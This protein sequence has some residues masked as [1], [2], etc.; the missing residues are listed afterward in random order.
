MALMMTT[1]DTGNVRGVLCGNP[2]I[3]VFK[4][5]PYGAPTSGQN[6][7]APPQPAEK[8]TGE[9][10]CDSFPDICY[11]PEMT[12]G[13]PFM[14]FFIKEFYP[15]RYPMSENSLALNVWTPAETPTEKLPV[16]VWIHGGGLSTGYGHEM[17]FDGEAIARRGVVLVTI[18][19][20]VDVLGWFAHPD[21]TRESPYDMSGNNWLFDQIAALQWV[22]RNIGAFGGDPANVTIFGQSAGGG[23]VVSHLISSKSNGLFAKAIIQ[24]GSFGVAGDTRMSTQ[25]SAGEAWGVKACEILSQSVVGLRAMSGLEAYQALKYAEE[26]GAGPAP[27]QLIDPY[28]LP[29]SAA[30]AFATGQAKNIPLMVGSVSGDGGL[31][32]EPDLKPDERKKHAIQMRLGQNADEFFTQFSLDGSGGKIADAIINAGPSL[33][34]MAVALG[35]VKN[36]HLP[37]YVYYFDP[38]IPEH[39]IAPFVEDGLAYHS[40]EMWYIFGVLNRCWR[41]F[42]GRHFD[43][44][45]AMTD[46]WTNFA[47]TG[48]PNG[49]GLPKWPAFRADQQSMLRL[50]ERRIIDESL[51][52]DDLDRFF[53]FFHESLT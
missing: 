45:Q 22:Q 5:I 4:G 38:F 51:Q 12:P 50:N 46:Y 47:K 17:E 53:A 35:Q 41:R 11:Q 40:S 1:I 25:L 34:D 13:I 3:T 48:N 27:R 18:Q 20:R 14:D 43:L 9:R 52:S 36:G 26:N 23:S 29:M 7:F 31:F 24:S 33:G 44:S 2:L 30:K 6:R 42:D 49:S 37:S 16:M 32:V 10:I 15:H 39:N 8:W 19:Y 21:L 28:L